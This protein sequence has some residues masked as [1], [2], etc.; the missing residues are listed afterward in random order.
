VSPGS[1]RILFAR[2]VDGWVL[3]HIP[4]TGAAE[5]LGWN[6]AVFNFSLSQGGWDWSPDGTEIVHTTSSFAGGGVSIGKMK[7]TTTQATYTDDLVLVGRD[8]PV[9]AVQDRQPSWRP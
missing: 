4:A 1:D 5:P 6:T 9:G 8:G 7:T 2:E 3:I